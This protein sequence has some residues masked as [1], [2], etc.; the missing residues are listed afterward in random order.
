[1]KKKQDISFRQLYLLFLA[2]LVLLM[3]LAVLHVRTILREYEGAQPERA[4]EAAI[5]ELKAA[6]E[7]GTFWTKY[8]MPVIAPGELESGRNVKQEYLALYTSDSVTYT[9]RSSDQDSMLYSVESEGYPLAE[10]RLRA[11]GE[12]RTRLAIFTMR[13]WLLESVEP[14]LES[15]DYTLTVPNTFSV[16]VN[17]VPLTEGQVGSSNTTYTVSGLYLKPDFIIADPQGNRANYA[18]RN[19]KVIPDIY[20]YSLTLP[21]AL[22]VTVDGQAQ[23]GEP[24]GDGMVRH[25][26]VRLTKPEVTVSDHYGNTVSYEGGNNL[27]LTRANILASDRYTV[28][29]DG[30]SVAAGDVTTEINPEY[31]AFAEFVPDLP[32]LTIYQV[33]ILKDD[34]QITVTDPA[35]SPVALEPG[36]TTYDLTGSAGQ[37]AVPADIAAQVDVLRVAKNW[38]LFMSQDLS[39][40]NL[41]PSL[42]KGSSMYSYVRTYA[43]SIDITFTSGHTFADPPFTGESVSNYKRISDHCFSVDISLVKHMILAHN[44]GTYDDSMNDR[45]YFVWF[46]DTDDGVNNPAWKLAGMTEIVNDGE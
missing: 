25:E 35:G 41:A 11:S 37:D 18:L 38:S 6:A 44:R 7:D 23:E 34:A 9:K 14:S 24:Q 21:A 22:T 20:H 31:N 10:V 5:G 39:F 19:G 12:P 33:A 3:I 36:Q 32:L 17:G 1:M 28:L 8:N 13:D 45:F 40:S 27:P 16:S 15:H 46:D 43:N 42:L 30:G 4:V 2:L 29:V 26:I